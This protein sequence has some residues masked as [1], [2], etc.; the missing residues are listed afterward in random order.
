MSRIANDNSDY[1]RALAPDDNIIQPFQLESSGL[2]GR[3]V[4]LGTVLNDIL[5]AH[6]YPGPVAHL[7]AETVATSLLLSSM[8]KY[9]GIFTL[10]ASA[11]GPVRTI[12]S[13]VTTAGA[14]RGYAGYAEDLIKA[15]EYAAE[16]NTGGTYE[17]LDLRQLTTKGYLAFTVDQGTNTERYQGIVELAG[18]QIADSVQHYFNQSEQ[19]GTT[20]KVAAS[21]DEKSGWRA[22]AIMLQR[23]PDPSIGV[24][25]TEHVL[26]FHGESAHE[27]EEDWNRAEVL[28]QSVVNDELVSEALHSHDLLVRLFHEEG[29]RI[30]TPQ[31]VFKSCRC[32]ADKVQHILSTLN[33]EDRE[34]A[35][36]NGVI[37]MTCEFCSKT[38]RFRSSDMSYMEDDDSHAKKH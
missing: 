15:M 14:V 19:I 29:V 5:S 8:L 11:E 4:R 28:L 1:N 9:D 6:S 31:P 20:L 21:Y 38:Y 30:F 32:S 17:G 10:Q 24:Q 12:V 7:L 23:M 2:R 3:V 36:N 18:D 34:H 22:G 35:A 37:E 13:D 16:G 25:E 26:P 27:K 33:E